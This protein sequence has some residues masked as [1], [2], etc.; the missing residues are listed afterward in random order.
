MSKVL[1][2]TV[3]DEFGCVNTENNDSD[4]VVLM[5]SQSLCADLFQMI[6]EHPIYK[7][8]VSTE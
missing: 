3:S 4:K 7:L 6:R 8:E 5:S 1:K 2:I